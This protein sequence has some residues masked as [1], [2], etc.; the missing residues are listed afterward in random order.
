M[1]TRNPYEYNPYALDDEARPR[2]VKGLFD[3]AFGMIGCLAASAAGQG[4]AL[5][6][7]VRLGYTA[8][9]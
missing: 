3:Q 4:R 1:N 8:T 7:F 5:G 9:R 6:L 2:G